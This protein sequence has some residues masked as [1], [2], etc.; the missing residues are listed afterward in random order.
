MDKSSSSSS[1]TSSSKPTED[2]LKNLN[3]I[4][5]AAPVGVI[6][7]TLIIIL[8]STLFKTNLGEDENNKKS[9]EHPKNPKINKELAVEITS[10]VFI[11]LTFLLVAF[12]ILYFVFPG[13]KDNIPRFFSVMSSSV[14]VLVYT[15]V[16]IIFFLSFSKQRLDE[17]SILIVPLTMIS[18][19]YMFYN[20]LMNKSGQ[21]SSSKF[22]FGLSGTSRYNYRYNYE[23]I[24]SVILFFCLLTIS[25]V[26]Y[27]VDPGGLIKEYFGFSLLL[28]ILFAA[29]ALIFLIV[30]IVSQ[31]KSIQSASIFSQFNNVSF[32]G[33]LA[34][35][36]FLLFAIIGM[37]QYP[38]GLSSNKNVMAE[39]I[40]I[41]LIVCIIWGIGL[42]INV[43]PET[44]SSSSEFK[45]DQSFLS[46]GM[47]TVFSILT[48][49]A[50]IA[51]L[52]YSIQHLSGRSGITSF[53]LNLL[54]V[55]VFM[56]LI[57]KTVFV[58]LPN[59]STDK[60][61]NVFFSLLK[62]LI[63]YIPCLFSSTFFKITGQEEK[64][65]SIGLLVT[66][67]IL[68]SLYLT[69]PFDL[70]EKVASQG[71]KLLINHP[72]NIDKY[73]A[74]ASY[75]DLNGEKDSFDY[76]YALSFWVFITP[77][78]SSSPNNK[79]VTI[80][81]YGNKPNILYQAS[82]NSI[83]I[84]MDQ[85]DLRRELTG[86]N[87]LTDFDEHGNRII[88]QS[89]DFPLQKWNNIVVNY[90]GG[91]LDVFIN[92]ELVKSASGVLP[93]MK[94]DTLSVGA[95]DG[96]KGGICNLVYFNE[97]LTTTN[98]YYLYNTVSQ[99]N[100]PISSSSTETIMPLK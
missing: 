34:F 90:S 99:L 70:I 96:V 25:I 2:V 9:N 45:M 51:W 20:A 56:L 63:F 89:K 46:R 95:E 29:F 43:F 50:F 79:F 31:E 1:S 85:K 17:Y 74:I 93:Y 52:T 30:T 21:S 8:F 6:L 47:L 66:M 41:M 19:G 3:T 33:T 38:G 91:T 61:K 10:D 78:N 71:G 75:H 4:Q 53:I 49:G 69:Y 72:I 22:N 59:E 26:Y 55:L 73:N 57:Y 5:I 84:T 54:I 15:I 77:T 67:I 44:T 82:T 40:V 87:K 42:I 92:N 16:F 37:Y 98:M 65:S 100:P 97:P 88:Y 83:M 12:G 14:S 11:V 76:Q 23:R 48:S 81:D 32:Y 27:S 13:F 94:Y 28:A 36:L 58:K 68:V 18:T 24:K 62:N 35:I 80:L 64:L 39:V 86:K 7:F 60:K